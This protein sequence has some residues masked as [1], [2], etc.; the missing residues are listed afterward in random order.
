MRRSGKEEDSGRDGEGWRKVE[1]IRDE[2]RRKERDKLTPAREN[3]VPN[4]WMWR[5][6]RRGRGAV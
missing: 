4:G 6:H 5:E 2:N 3:G 1:G